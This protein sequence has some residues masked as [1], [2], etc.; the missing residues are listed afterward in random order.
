MSLDEYESEHKPMQVDK[1]EYLD[2]IN[3]VIH[4]DC[5]EVMQKI[6]PKS[7]DMIFSQIYHTDTTSC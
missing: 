3:K 7:V 5:L 4:G 6:K 2:C 1:V